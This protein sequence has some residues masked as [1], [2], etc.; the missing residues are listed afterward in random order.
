M[1]YKLGSNTNS[2]MAC[3][4]DTCLEISEFRQEDRYWGCNTDLHVLLG[5]RS[6]NPQM[7]RDSRTPDLML[8][9]LRG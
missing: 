1:D 9:L 2:S 7:N 4:R 3:K 5:L 8:P 6:A